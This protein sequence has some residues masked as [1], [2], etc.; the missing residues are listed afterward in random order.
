MSRRRIKEDE[1]NISE[2]ELNLVPYLDIMVNLIMFM[3]LTFQV[4]A[5]LRI[6][7]FNPPAS[8]GPGAGGEAAEEERK[9]L[10]TVMITG[11][12]HKLLTDDVDAGTQTVPLG[13]DGKHDFTKL[14]ADL[15]KLQEN[16]PQIDRENLVIVAEPQIEYELVV[17]TMDAARTTANGEDLFP[18]VTL[19]MAV[20]TQ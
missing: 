19:G 5:E 2:G 3:L 7:N 16:V 1:F 15:Q 13:A 9:L 17:K 11:S 14:Q 20:G 6:I 8:G 12:G 4:V 10:L 18:N